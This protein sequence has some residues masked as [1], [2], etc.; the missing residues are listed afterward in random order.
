MTTRVIRVTIHMSF[1]HFP[2]GD[3]REYIDRNI[4]D[5]LV[6]QFNQT[7][8]VVSNYTVIT[9][10]HDVVVDARLTVTSPMPIQELIR[11]LDTLIISICRTSE[12]IV[13]LNFHENHR[14]LPAPPRLPTRLDRM[15]TQF[16]RSLGRRGKPR[17]RPT[18][19]RR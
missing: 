9:L 4:F 17:K 15:Y 10:R 13:R 5:D 1:E 3:L 18:R 8:L 19:K 14:Y 11:E 12:F 2:E 6:Y 16:K 7:S